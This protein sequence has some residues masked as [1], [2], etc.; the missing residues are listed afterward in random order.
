M[1]ANRSHDILLES[2]TNE[3][4]VLVFTLAGQKYGVNV[5]KVREVLEPV[6][7]TA[8]PEAHF[9]VVGVF[10]LRENV[11]PL[12]DLKK[13][14]RVEEDSGIPTRKIIIMEFNALRMGFLVDT[15]EQIYR[16]SWKDVVAL[17]DVEGIREAPI[18]SIAYI[19][20]DLTPMLD[21]EKLMFDVGGMDLFTKDA[22]E[23]NLGVVRRDQRLLLAEDSHIMRD[24]IRTKLAE[25]G[26]TNVEV[27]S[28][29]TDA[30]ERLNDDVATNGEPTYDL[31]ITDI[32]MPQ[33]DGLHLTRRIKE[34]ERMRHVPVV[35]ISSLVSDDNEKKCKAVGADAQIAK[36]QLDQLVPLID[37]LIVAARKSPSPQNSEAA[38]A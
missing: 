26:Y 35:V 21:F 16:V 10:Q 33:M 19:K 29:G 4:E 6:P 27:C 11:T 23:S 34:H 38:L 22:E 13:C 3:L 2:G 9:A 24:M 32:E 36:P 20:D 37:R 12:I 25:A 8:V 14:L 1:T 18:T 5:A 31:L 15:V 28:N 30:W 17:P 7:I